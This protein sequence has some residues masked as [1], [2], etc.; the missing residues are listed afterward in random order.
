[1]GYFSQTKPLTDAKEQTINF[2]LRPSDFELEAFV[3]EAGENPAFEIIGRAV[4]KK[5]E[6]DKRNL[7]AY[8]TKNYTKIEIDIDQV[9]ESFTQRKAVQKVTNVLDSIKQLTNDEGEKILPIFFS[10]TL[11]KFYF[12]NNP[13]LKK[14]L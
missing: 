14:K 13:E 4:A 7:E 9:S 11:S 6:F 3:F 2:Q 10:E 12:R 8:E 1:M 5:K